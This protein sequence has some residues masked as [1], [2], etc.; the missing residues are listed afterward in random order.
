[1][2]GSVERRETFAKARSSDDGLT[3][4]S[5]G[6]CADDTAV[7]DQRTRRQPARSSAE[8][9]E[10]FGASWKRGHRRSVPSRRST[11]NLF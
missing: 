9:E 1:M 4:G 7:I 5:R 8:S 3:L 2:T 6:E 11:A 10:V